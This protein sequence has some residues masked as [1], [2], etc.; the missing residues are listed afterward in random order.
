VGVLDSI[1]TRF[2]LLQVSTHIMLGIYVVLIVFDSVDL[3]L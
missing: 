3:V 2:E 1:K